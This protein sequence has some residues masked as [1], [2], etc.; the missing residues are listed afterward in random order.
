MTYRT[1]IRRT[2]LLLITTTTVLVSSACASSLTDPAPT[3]L[4]YCA[5]AVADSDAAGKDNG[6]IPAEADV[7]STET[8]R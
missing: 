2:I 1:H 8:T 5:E 4:E 3:V 7:A 6:C